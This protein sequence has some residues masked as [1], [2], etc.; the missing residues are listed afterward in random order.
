MITGAA[1]Q[2]TGNQRY[3]LFL[4]VWDFIICEKNNIPWS[5]RGSAPVP[6]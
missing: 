3:S 4:I 6:L 1:R 2:E 5:G